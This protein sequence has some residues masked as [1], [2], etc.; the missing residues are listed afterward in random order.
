MEILKYCDL[1]GLEI[2]FKT[3]CQKFKFVS[4]SAKSIPKQG[5]ETQKTSVFVDKL[6]SLKNDIAILKH[7]NHKDGNITIQTNF[8]FLKF[9]N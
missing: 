7:I 8:C 1:Y 9:T 4:F 5:S 3:L 6:T 2:I